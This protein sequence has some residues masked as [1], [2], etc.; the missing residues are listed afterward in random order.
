MKNILQKRNN[1]GAK[2]DNAGKLDIITFLND[3]VEVK[4]MYDSKNVQD[5]KQP[6]LCVMLEM[7]MREYTRIGKNNG[8]VYFMD[9]ET[10]ILS[11]VAEL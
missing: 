4:N 10:A 6:G 2:C 8:K 11:G 7:I 3:V 1:I 5:I 9:A